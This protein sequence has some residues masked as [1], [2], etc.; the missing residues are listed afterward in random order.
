MVMAAFRSTT[1]GKEASKLE[2]YIPAA[3]FA[4]QGVYLAA[5]QPWCAGVRGKLSRLEARSAVELALQVVSLANIGVIRCRGRLIYG[6]EAAELIITVRQLLN[7]TKQIVL[8]LAGVTQI[9]SGGVGALGEAFVAAHNRDAEIKLAALSPRVAE[10]LR[11]TGLDMLFDTHGSEAEA[12]E[13]FF[14]RSQAETAL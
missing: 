10:V 2:A 5:R 7:T 8:Q 12:I 11:I 3:T 4:A 9:D 6:L 13:A 14:T 1:A